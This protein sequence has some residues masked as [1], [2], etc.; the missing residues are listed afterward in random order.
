MSAILSGGEIINIHIGSAGGNIGSSFWQL[1]AKEH[2]LVTSLHLKKTQK[3]RGSIGDDDRHQVSRMLASSSY[4]VGEERERQTGLA[5]QNLSVYFFETLQRWI[6]RT[7]FVDS[8]PSARYSGLFEP[9]SPL[10]HFF[11]PEN[12]I[13]GRTGSSGVRSRAIS[14]GVG[15]TQQ[16]LN[17][18]MRE[19]ELA[20]SPQAIQLTHHLGGGSGSG[21]G[22]ILLECLR[23]EFGAKIPLIPTSLIPVTQDIGR[24]NNAVEVYNAVLSLPEIAEYSDL[25]FFIDNQALYD[26]CF[27]LVGLNEPGWRDLN[28]IVGAVMCG[29]SS[30]MR[31]PSIHSNRPTVSRLHAREMVSVL[32]VPNLPFAIPGFAPLSNRASNA[33]LGAFLLS[34]LDSLEDEKPS[35][36]L[37]YRRAGTRMPSVGE[38]C[39]SLFRPSH[40]LGSIDPLGH[41]YLSAL[42]VFRGLLDPDEIEQ[43]INYNR[44]NNIDRYREWTQSMPSTLTTRIW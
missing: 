8:D 6:P 15:I 3:K 16:A 18:L 42:A 37:R 36:L 40:L 34:G 23:D 7:I 24:C 4:D 41:H 17:A 38:L 5:S 22:C 19:M 1:I 2:H 32:K 9:R 43:E 44:L 21:L 14:E 31:F 39:R 12:F 13:F 27:K 20:D 28:H 35:Q 29:F 25:S 10:K 26:I 33:P 11:R 30:C